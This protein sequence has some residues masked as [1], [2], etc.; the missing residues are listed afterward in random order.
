[1]T[2]TIAGLGPGDPHM[3]TR[4]VW[5]TLLEAD[6]V[7]LRTR[8]HPSVAALPANLTLISFDDLYDRADDFDAIYTTIVECLLEAATQQ[9]DLLYAVPGDPLVGEASVTYLLAEA[10]SQGIDV[11]ILNGI[12]FV[13]PA[14]AALASHAVP[15]DALDGLQIADALEVGQAYH[16]PLNPD[17]PAL[18]A[19]VYS[20]Q[21]ASELKLT[22]MNQYPD[23]HIVWL[24]HSAG[25]PDQQVESLPLYEI[26]RNPRLAHLTTLYLP[27]MS[28]PEGI[29]ESEYEA[30][31]TSF[32]GFQNTIAHLRAPEG[33]PWDREQT[34]QSLRPHL[35]EETYEVLSAIDSGDPDLLREELGDLLLQVVL[36]SQIAVDDG[37]FHMGEVIAHIDAKLKYRHPHVWGEVEA[38]TPREVKANW[39]QLKAAERKD[40]GNESGSSL[41]GVPKT[42]PALAQAHTYDTRAARLGFD[43]DDISGVLDKLNEEIEEVRNASTPQELAAEIGDVLFVVASWARWLNVE[44]ES[45]LREAN[46]RFYNRFRHLEQLAQQ[47]GRILTDMST[48]ELEEL[49]QAAKQATSS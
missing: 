5:Q 45:A 17:A 11:R 25:T 22:L 21:A 16:P 38:N 30:T 8:Q 23:Q 18:I 20:R 31:A 3:I 15:I 28:P 1:M 36:H 12:S 10:S 49:W 24:L 27:P 44:P 13:E 35:L 2:I 29:V 6:K 46:R 40:S 33:C 48:D 43:W 4:S 19:Q 32:E 9:G 14:L 41:D 47:Q 26:D 39:E 7:Y 34:H 37:E 42:L